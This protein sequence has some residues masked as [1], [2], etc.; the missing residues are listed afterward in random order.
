MN[1]TFFF[2][3]KNEEFR[4]SK[5]VSQGLERQLSGWLGTQFPLQRTQVHIPSTCMATHNHL[6][7]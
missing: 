1:V 3:K 5:E 4:E 7:L 2:L 6:E